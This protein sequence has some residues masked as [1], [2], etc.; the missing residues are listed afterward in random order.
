MLVQRLRR[1]TN[2]KPP[3]DERHL[4][5]PRCKPERTRVSIK[6]SSRPAVEPAVSTAPRPP[7]RRVLL[8][9]RVRLISRCAPPGFQLDPSRSAGGTQR[10]REILVG[11]QAGDVQAWPAT[12]SNLNSVTYL[13][14][15]AP[16]IAFCQPWLAATFLPRKTTCVPSVFDAGFLFSWIYI[17]RKFRIESW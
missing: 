10:V 4:L 7:S 1:W 15:A 16:R 5:D 6:K 11:R 9:A 13:N 12:D 17:S 8:M 3:P 2:I 14:P